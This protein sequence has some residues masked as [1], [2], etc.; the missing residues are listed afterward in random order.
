MKHPRIMIAIIIVTTG[1]LA[2]QRLRAS[3][4]GLFTCAANYLPSRNVISIVITKKNKTHFF[5]KN[6]INHQQIII[7]QCAKYNNR[8]TCRKTGTNP[9]WGCLGNP[10]AGHFRAGSERLAEIRWG[11]TKEGGKNKRD[12]EK[13]KVCKRKLAYGQRTQATQVPESS[14]AVYKGSQRK[15]SK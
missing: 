2:G 10:W 1:Q 15:L 7:I 8:L 14:S 5:L 9:L 6:L 12:K 3:L 4:G 13:Y 11:M